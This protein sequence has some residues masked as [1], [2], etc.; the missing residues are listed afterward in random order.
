MHYENV[1]QKITAKWQV[2]L[3][4]WPLTKF[5]SLSSIVTRNEVEILYNAFKTGTAI[6]HQFSNAKRE[7]WDAA[8]FQASLNM[9][10]APGDDGVHVGSRGF[11]PG[12][13][14]GMSTIPF[15]TNPIPTNIFVKNTTNLTPLSSVPAPLACHHSSIWQLPLLMA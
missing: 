11:V 7:K 2:A 4:G 15:L 9:T 14:A 5:S 12:L 8:Y 10:L 13:Q 6:F 3:D 1:D